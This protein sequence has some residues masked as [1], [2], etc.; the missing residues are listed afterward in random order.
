MDMF[1]ESFFARHDPD[2][3]RLQRLVREILGGQAFSFGLLDCLGD[4]SGTLLGPGGG[5]VRG[6][7][8]V[9]GRIGD[10]D[11]TRSKVSWRVQSL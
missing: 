1:N 2:H 6:F 3:P 7:G 4:S 5:L 8:S 10:S 9:C 11:A